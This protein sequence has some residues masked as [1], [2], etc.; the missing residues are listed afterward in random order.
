MDTIVAVSSPPG[1]GARAV[2]RLSGSQSRQIVAAAWQSETLA[3]DLPGHVDAGIPDSR[4]VLSGAFDDGK[5]LL[6]GFLFWMPGPASYT[7]EDVVELHLPGS[8]PLVDAVLARLFHL[9]ARLAQPGEFTRRAFLNGRLD[10]TRAEG[11]LGLIEAADTAA[12]RSASKLL[13]GGL[14]QR[15]SALREGLESLRALAEASLDFD[16][17]ETGH[18][19]TTELELRAG[20][21]EVELGEALL[22]EQRR[23]PAKGRPRVLLAGRPNAGK[24]SLF[25][26]LTSEVRA[27]QAEQLDSRVAL[28]EALVSSLAGSTRDGVLGTWR[29]GGVDVELMDAPGLEA[30]LS[31]TSADGRAQELAARERTGA[32]LLLWAVDGSSMVE[33]NRDALA[34]ERKQL[35]QNTPGNSRLLCLVTKRDLKS[36]GLSMADAA[37]LVDLPPESCLAISTQTSAGL[38]QLAARVAQRLGLAAGQADPTVVAAA[39]LGRELSARHRTAIQAALGALE[40]ALGGLRAGLPLDLVAETLREGTLELD[41]ITGETTP[42]DLLDRIFAGFCLGK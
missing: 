37:G 18:V 17:A 26:V 15:M 24:S 22:W 36:S 29:L 14:E 27:E 38:D 25:N 3:G 2:V 6:P 23:E 39:A 33:A 31:D 13:V 20:K 32:D 9:G 34:T 30:E 41:A 16:T 12:Q 21:L 11:V 7:R 40:E 10:L 4:A 5:S 8:P 35:E 19:D 1:P 42:E 28:G